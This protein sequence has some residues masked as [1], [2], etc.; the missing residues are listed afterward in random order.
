MVLQNFT[1]TLR[2][3]LQYVLNSFSLSYSLKLRFSQLALLSSSAKC[4]QSITRAPPVITCL[5]NQ[6]A[7]AISKTTMDE[8]LVKEFDPETQKIASKYFVGE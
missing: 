1:H 6:F 4:E 8:V 2:S 3:N 7:D 5:L